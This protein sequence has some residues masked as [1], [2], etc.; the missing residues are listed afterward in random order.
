M[1]GFF[2]CGW[3]GVTAPRLLSPPQL[4]AHLWRHM[5]IRLPNPFCNPSFFVRRLDTREFF[6][7]LFCYQC[8]CHMQI[9]LLSLAIDTWHQMVGNDRW[10][11]FLNQFGNHCQPRNSV[12]KKLVN[13]LIVMYRDSCKSKKGAF[14]AQ[15]L[16]PIFQAKGVMSHWLRRKQS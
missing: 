16:P 5:Q 12:E 7:A 9:L 13:Q 1:W 15:S 11:L 4:W 8:L 14:R 2:M 3:P 6:R 10:S